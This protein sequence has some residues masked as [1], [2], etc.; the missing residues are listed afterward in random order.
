[1]K[2]IFLIFII[3]LISCGPTED[4]IQARIDEAVE[5]ASNTSSSTTSSSTTSTT[6]TVPKYGN[7]EISESTSA[8]DDST[9]VIANLRSKKEVESKNF[10]SYPL[11]QLQCSGGNSEIY[12]TYKVAIDTGLVLTPYYEG[13]LG[14]VAVNIRLDKNKPQRLIVKE[15]A[16]SETVFISNPETLLGFMA[17][18]K[19]M[20]FEFTPFNSNSDY[21]EFEINGIEEVLK[22]MQKNCYHR[23]VEAGLLAKKNNISNK[24]WVDATAEFNWGFGYNSE[25]YLTE[26]RLGKESGGKY[27]L[28]VYFAGQWSNSDREKVVNHIFSQI[29]PYVNIKI[30]EEYSEFFTDIVLFQDQ[31]EAKKYYKNLPDNYLGADGKGWNIWTDNNGYYWD[32]CAIWFDPTKNLDPNIFNLCLGNAKF[33]FA[34]DYIPDGLSLN[35]SVQFNENIFFENETF[36]LTEIDKAILGLL[37]WNSYDGMLGYFGSLDNFKQNLSNYDIDTP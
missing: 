10:S 24:K 33:W 27:P 37:Y 5:E 6:T 30:G 35:Y 9:T 36:E 15:G 31:G 2:K 26:I 8:L 29:Y 19:T 7:W 22:E 4:E 21:A 32:Y 11:L 1:M 13:D 34:D 17:N 25:G 12:G 20:L 23:V 14:D 28:D 16:N 18:S 3:F